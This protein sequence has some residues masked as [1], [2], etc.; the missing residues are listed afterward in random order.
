[1]QRYFLQILY[2]SPGISSPFNVV[3]DAVQAIPRAGQVT[4]L[5]EKYDEQSRILKKI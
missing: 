4:S 1:L 2:S 5:T 3:E